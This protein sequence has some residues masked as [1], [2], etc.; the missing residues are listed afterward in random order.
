MQKLFYCIYMVATMQPQY[1]IGSLVR[2][3]VHSVM[4]LVM[5]TTHFIWPTGDFTSQGRK[6]Q[7]SLWQYLGTE[8][9]TSPLGNRKEQACYELNNHTYA[10]KKFFHKKYFLHMAFTEARKIFLN[11]QRKRKSFWSFIL[12]FII[13]FKCK[14]FLICLSL[15]H[16]WQ[17]GAS[18]LRS[19]TCPWSTRPTPATM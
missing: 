13:H 2:F 18:C 9:V 12:N 10:P 19:P 7:P 3:C 8:R 5:S 1:F 15:C 16:C 17:R 11:F 14:W 6:P 4:A